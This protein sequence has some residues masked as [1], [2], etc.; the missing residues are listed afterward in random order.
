MRSPYPLAQTNL[1]EDR[2]PSHRLGFDLDCGAMPGR[3]G[4]VYSD[5]LVHVLNVSL[6]VCA[7]TYEDVPPITGSLYLTH[8]HIGWGPMP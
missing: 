4:C 1:M 7:V 5:S 6:C 3:G 2:T 8:V